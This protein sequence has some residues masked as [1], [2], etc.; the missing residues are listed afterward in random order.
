MTVVTARGV[1]FLRGAAVLE[2]V[3][4]SFAKNKTS[5]KTSFCITHSH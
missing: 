4:D 2:W 5:V 1:E 3:L